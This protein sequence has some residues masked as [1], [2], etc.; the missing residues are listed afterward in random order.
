MK[1]PRTF[2]EWFT[3]QDRAELVATVVLAV[4][5]IATAWSGFPECEV[6][7]GAGDCLQ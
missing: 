7:W 1:T 2:A 5:A 4:A 6:E 3:A